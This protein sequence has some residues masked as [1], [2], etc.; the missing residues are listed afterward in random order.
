MTFVHEEA[1]FLVIPATGGGTLGK[2]YPDR[3]KTGSS[4]VAFRLDEANGDK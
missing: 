4:F 1:Q 2:Y 3:V